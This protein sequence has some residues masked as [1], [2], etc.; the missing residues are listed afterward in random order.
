MTFYLLAW[1][2]IAYACPWGLGHSPAFV[3]EMVCSKTSRIDINVYT[4]MDILQKQL[5]S[6]GPSV[7]SRIIRLNGGRAEAMAVNWNPEVK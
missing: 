6:L 4:K 5:A 3:K 2:N 7:P 1:L